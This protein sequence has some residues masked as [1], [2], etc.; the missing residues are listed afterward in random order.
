MQD[1]KTV[2][3]WWLV[4]VHLNGAYIPREC[5]VMH[6]H[7]TFT[8]NETTSAEKTTTTTTR[9]PGLCL[10]ALVWGCGRLV[11][12]ASLVARPSDV[13][14]ADMSGCGMMPCSLNR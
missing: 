5:V 9:V 13:Y 6:L 11:Y 4:G 7:H 2:G 1:I 3:V 12:C 14:S 8:V 10:F